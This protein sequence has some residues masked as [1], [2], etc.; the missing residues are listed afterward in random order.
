MMIRISNKNN[1]IPKGAYHFAFLILACLLLLL[2]WRT[3]LDLFDKWY[4]HD[5]AGTY[6]HGLLVLFITIYLVVLRIRQNKSSFSLITP[7]NTGLLFFACSQAI[8]FVAILAGVNFVQHIALLFSLLTLVWALY[9]FNASKLFVR[10]ALLLLLTFPLWGSLE[11]PLQNLT[12]LIT[13]LILK[14]TDVPYYRTGAYFHF[15]SGIIEIAPEC[16]GLQQLLVSL[17]IGLI[18]SLQRELPMRDT[19]KMLIYI[20]IAALLI[21]V[22][23]IIVIMIVGYYTA[24]E[25]SLITKHLVLGWVIYGVGIYAFLYFYS[26]KKFTFHATHGG[27]S[28]LDKPLKIKFISVYIIVFVLIIF[29]T[30]TGKMITDYINNR[31]AIKSLNLKVIDSQWHQ[32]LHAFPVYWKPS[33]PRG[34]EIITTT[35][36]KNDA[37]VYLYENRFFRIDEDIEPVNMVNTVYNPKVWNVN[38][39]E[40]ISVVDAKGKHDNVYL[41]VLDSRSHGKLV[42]LSFYVINGSLVTSLPQAKIATLLGLLRLKYDTRVVCLATHS[43][44]DPA[45]AI[46]RLKQFY[47]NLDMR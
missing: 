22:L 45:D 37:N 3:I 44:D 8:L 29:P 16:A 28:D 35:Y 21:N 19:V 17:V 6:S 4:D 14:I 13:D 27:A 23:R 10:P 46:L 5:L 39:V 42:V 31:R 9:S 43:N 30:L 1:I 20:S 41:N 18:F 36:T 26:K 33:F 38:Q 11:Y 15:P 34:D 2:N 25:S 47:Q 32:Q 7:S 40:K 24:M 12:V